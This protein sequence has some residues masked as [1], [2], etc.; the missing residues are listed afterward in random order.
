MEAHEAVAH[1]NTWGDPTFWVFLSFLVFVAVAWK[2]G[3]API[4]NILDARTARIRAELEEAER[5][6]AEAQDLLAETQRKHRDAVQ[7]AKKIIDTAKQTAERLHGEAAVKLEETLKNREAQLLERIARAETAA[8]QQLRD[9]AADIATQAAKTLLA[10]SVEKR[11]AKLV[12]EA[13]GDIPARL[14]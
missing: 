11:G 8:V 1:A 2:K 6:R 9:Q 13:I 5:L 7:S 14:N 12:D 4:V 10:E 3:R